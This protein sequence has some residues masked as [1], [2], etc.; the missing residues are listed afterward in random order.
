M[1]FSVNGRQVMQGD[2]FNQIYS[3]SIL[4][5]LRPGENVVSIIAT[6]G[7]ETPNPAGFIA[8]IQLTRA[9]GGIRTIPAEAAA[10]GAIVSCLPDAPLAKQLCKMGCPSVRLGSLPHPEDALLPA[11]VPDFAAAGRLAADHFAERGFREVGFVGC[12]PTRV[13]ENLY[14]C[15]RAFE[16]RLTELGLRCHLHRCF[17][18]AYGTTPQ[19]YRMRNAE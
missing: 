1:P 13:G 17:Q 15:Y 12:D 4:A 8:A 7:G 6:N 3:A 2:N 19:K 16:A 9:D 10:A 18:H 11:V 14:T 5:A